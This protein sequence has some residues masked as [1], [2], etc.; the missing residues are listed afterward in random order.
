MCIVGSPDTCIKQI[1]RLQREARLDK[2]LCMMQ[3]WSLP[4][5]RTMHAIEL[6]GKHVIPCF[7]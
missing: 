1:D 7:S 3:F 2:L 6:L 4:H 5:D